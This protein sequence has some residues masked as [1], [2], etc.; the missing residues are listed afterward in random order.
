[1]LTLR[2]TIQADLF[3]HQGRAGMPGFVKTLRFPGFRYSVV[4]RICNRL[5][6]SGN[7]FGKLASVPARLILRHYSYKFG[8]QIPSVTN[9]GPGLHI[10][11]VGAIVINPDAVIGCNVNL[12]PG[13]TIGQTDRGKKQGSP[14]IGNCV[15]IG[16]N[17]VIV[18]RIKIGN[19]VLIAPGSYVVSD[20]PDGAVVAGN[21]ASI[22][23]Y[24]GVAGYL[25][26]PVETT[27]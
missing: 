16:T 4:L 18:G 14:Q 5:H 13:V 23:S 25:N 10:N 1:M 8:Y 11:F 26:Y 27:A 20:V 12:H 2:R 24:G 7:V 22:V 15:W 9:I 17:S 19:N 21:P 6:R 3:R